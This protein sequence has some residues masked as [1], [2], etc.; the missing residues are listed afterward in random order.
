MFGGEVIS[1]V[2]YRVVY[3]FAVC[4]HVYYRGNTVHESAV[5]VYD[6]ELSILFAVDNMKYTFVRKPHENFNEG[7]SYFKQQ[8][9]KS[10]TS[11]SAD[12]T[13]EEKILVFNR[14]R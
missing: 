6:L 2:T 12:K 9:R 4:L 13:E 11:D 7:R 8:K 1:A 5:C 14:S 10:R 3:C